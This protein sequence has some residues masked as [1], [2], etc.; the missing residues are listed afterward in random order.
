MEMRPIKAVAAWLLFAAGTIAI[1]VW[2]AG[3]VAPTIPI[4]CVLVDFETWEETPILDA[5][6]DV[7][8][9]YDEEAARGLTSNL[10]CGGSHNQLNHKII[11]R[12]KKDD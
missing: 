12:L 9:V 1:G 8:M 6:F 7:F 2:L 4:E 5:H 11:C 3:C 10:V